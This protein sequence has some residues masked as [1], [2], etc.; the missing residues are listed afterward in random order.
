[1]PLQIRRG[2]ELQRQAMTVPLA[3]GELLYVTDD[4]RLYVGNGSTLGGVQITGYTN[5]N[6]VDAVGAALVNGVHAGI[7]F[8]YGTIQDTAGRIDATID[9]SNYVGTLRADAIKG[10][11][12][13]DDS[14]V[15]VD[16]VAGRI[17]GPVFSNVVGNVTGN[18]TG[19]VTG[20]I[21]GIITGTAGSTLIGNVTGDLVGNS[22][23][24]H[25]G[26]MKGS[27]FAD[28]STLIVDGLNSNVNVNVLNFVNGRI[29]SNNID[30]DTIDAGSPINPNKFRVYSDTSSD[31]GVEIRGITNVNDSP[32]LS[33]ASSRGTL[34]SPTLVQDGD[35]LGGIIFSG[36]TAAVG[37]GFAAGF[38]I[39]AEAD[40][41]SIIT[42]DTS[43]AAT[44]SLASFPDFS[45]GTSVQI[46][47]GALLD[48]Q[49]IKTGS[50]ATI[51]LPASPEAGMIVFDSTTSEF[52]GWNGASWVILG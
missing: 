29:L 44:L 10:T 15:L 45:V 17:V 49:I 13:A 36:Y 41:A 4:Q 43:F 6:A 42:G 24:Y 32:T 20:N 28:N 47:P 5:E 3:S 9:L 7:T 19:N 14:T 12:V 50:F 35:A 37:T 27:V 31:V 16:A 38:V 22:T 23:G 2:T 46:R 21:N 18:L 40:D 48:A 8:T 33:F 39:S 51:S 34:G 25:F 30:A 1:M 52:K 26:D 11:I